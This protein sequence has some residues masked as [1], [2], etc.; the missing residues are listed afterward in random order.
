[1]NV[2]LAKVRG[3]HVRYVAKHMRRGDRDEIWASNH[4][5]PKAAL[6][7]GVRISRWSRT[8]LVEGV[9]ACIMGVSPRS[10]LS[11]IGTPWMLCTDQLERAQ[12][13]MLRLSH[14]MIDRML[15]EFPTLINWVDNRN[16]T[17]IKW[18]RW[19]GFDV[20]DPVPYGADQMLF[21]RFSKE[22]VPSARHS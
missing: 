20:E 18:L 2:G 7:E 9:P 8:G 15:A 12:R 17:A 19:L 16:V 11:G 1:M 21:C 6:V 4:I 22:K 14:A 5:L 10:I 3:D 13:P